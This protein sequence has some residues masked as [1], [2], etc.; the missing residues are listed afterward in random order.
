MK[1]QYIL[2]HKLTNKEQI[3]NAEEKEKF[4]QYQNKYHLLYSS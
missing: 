3:M 4:Y 2:K 1:T